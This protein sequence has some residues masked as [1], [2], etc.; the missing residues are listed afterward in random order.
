MGHLGQ[1]L[2]HK[3]L[4][5]SLA[6]IHR[7]HGLKGSGLQA[8]QSLLCMHPRPRPPFA[9]RILLLSSYF[10]HSTYKPGIILIMAHDKINSYHLLNA[11]LCI[12]YC[13]G[14]IFHLTVIL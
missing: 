12:R 6:K 7:C 8:S 4:L 1:L 2:F 3:L 14:F 13:T 10:L 11:Y 9:K 5:Y